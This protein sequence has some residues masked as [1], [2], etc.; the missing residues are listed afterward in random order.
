MNR[1]T[2]DIGANAGCP[3]EK[4]VIAQSR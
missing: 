2:F 1:K 3:V 4:R